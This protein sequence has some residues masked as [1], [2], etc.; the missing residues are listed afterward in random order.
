M[1]HLKPW[2]DNVDHWFVRVQFGEDKRRNLYSEL[3]ALV[4]AGFSKSEAIDAIWKILS[5]EG[6][7]MG[8]PRARILDSVRTGIRNGHG[9]GESLREWVPRDEYMTLCA[10]EHSDQFGH[11]LEIYCNT[12]KR[13]Q[14]IQ[15]QVIG[16]LA[17]PMLLLFTSYGMLVYFSRGISPKIDGL[18]PVEQW[19]GLSRTVFLVGEYCG[20]LMPLT[21]A[22]MIILPIVILA[23]LPRWSGY[24]RVVGDRLP[25]FSIYRLHTGVLLLQSIA[26]LISTGMTAVEAIRKIRPTANKYLGSRLDQVLHHLLN[27][28][29]LGHAMQ[30]TGDGWPDRNLVL[31]LR[32]LSRSQ[33]FSSNLLT[34]AERWTVTSHDRIRRTI[35]MARAI[36]FLM[37]FGAIST[38]VMAMYD[39]Q[40]Q[41][42]AA[43]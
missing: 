12:L 37:V 25:V 26:C 20:I 18:L 43:Y 19:T 38:I 2:F 35:S 32:V 10:I 15:T 29:N 42:T 11:H 21:T 23:T 34:I 41:I 6:K 8:D 5:S 3:V 1:I 28:S 16:T 39:L 24:G 27:G 14:G 4:K 36:I 30:M 22:I 17:Y 13:K 7:N 31:T 9:I 40:G 33:D